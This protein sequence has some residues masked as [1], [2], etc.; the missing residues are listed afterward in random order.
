VI[1]IFPNPAEN[2]ITIVGEEDELGQIKIYTT[3]G[4]DVTHLI[5]K[6]RY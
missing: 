1:E 6:N 5:Q 2:I 3:L 4:Q